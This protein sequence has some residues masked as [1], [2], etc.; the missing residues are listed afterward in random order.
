MGDYQT[1]LRHHE[2]DLR[3]GE[4][5][6]SNMRQSRAFGNLGLVY[7]L[8]QNYKKASEY[9]EQH[10]SMAAQLSDRVAKV[11][12]YSSL[13][14]NH[15]SMGNFAQSISFLK[16]GLTI[17]ETL[18]RSEDEANIRYWLGVALCAKKDV[19][20]SLEQ[21]YRAAD[22][23]ES[24]RDAGIGSGRFQLPMH[25]QQT[26]C[27]QVLQRVLIDLSRCEEALVVDERSCKRLC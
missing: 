7:E 8:M 26:L 10:L 27:Y 9:Q 21:L 24:L 23:Y 6:H 12:A 14:R 4:K 25:E 18:G 17:A 15:Y 22:M 16:Q 20:S 2:N 3:L 5:L 11:D 1:A 19:G 13:G